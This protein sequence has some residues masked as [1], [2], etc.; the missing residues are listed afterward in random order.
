MIP[1]IMAAAAAIGPIVSAIG[2]LLSQ[3]DRVA[4]MHLRE[5]AMAEY[6]IKLPDMEEIAAQQVHTNPNDA[7]AERDVYSQLLQEGRSGKLD[8][9][10]KA[11]LNEVE[12]SLAQHERGS[13]EAIGQTMQARGLSGSGSELAALLSNQQAGAARASQ[14][15]MDVA[16]MAADKSRSALTAAAGIAGG[17]RGQ[18]LS[19]GEYNAGQHAA[20]DVFN[21]GQKNTAYAQ[22]LGLA[23]RRYNAD[24]SAAAGREGSANQTQAT[25]GGVGQSLGQGAAGVGTYLNQQDV[26]NRQRQD[27]LDRANRSSQTTSGYGWGAYG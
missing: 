13:R 5:Q 21:V 10:D 3:G 6:N 15:G 9:A 22:R 7:Q 8:A 2:K 16:G 19:E 20:T 23:D 18:D 26:L 27:E 25:W 11:K 24:T 17:V 12:N 4:A 1:I 14:Q